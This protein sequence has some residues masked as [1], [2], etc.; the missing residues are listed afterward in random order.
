MTSM[1][2]RSGS[3]SGSKSLDH[4]PS[5]PA[6]EQ[7]KVNELRAALGP[8]TGRAE[9]YATDACLK[10][11]LRARNWNVKKSEKMLR[12]T[13]HWR[14][15]YKPEE[16]RWADVAKE[17]ETGKM[18]RA[19]FLDKQGQTLLAMHPVRQNT[20]EMD[21][22]IKHLVYCLENAIL[23][24]PIG[25]EQMIWL[26]DFRGWGIKY[27]IPIKTAREA[28]NIL[29]NHY[30]EQ[31]HVAILFSPPFVFEAFWMIVKP[32][33]DPKTFRKVKFVYS[34]NSESMKQLDG[35]L[36]KDRL[37]D[38]LDN[39]THYNHEE[40]AKLMEQDDMKSTAYWKIGE[41]QPQNGDLPD[42]GSM[43]KLEDSTEVKNQHPKPVLN[44]ETPA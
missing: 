39:P 24:L 27:T 44:G 1:L 20:S 7:V 22:Q 30:P 33:L 19:N 34:K 15:V 42:P 9:I 31:L 35:L 37:K 29:Q 13:L 4:E 16:I 26:V 36:L 40:Y 12:D 14:S 38:I 17:H 41:G 8:L 2:R 10:R 6:E 3:N 18:Y 5:S 11:Y 28:T 23:N 32:F 21:G 43:I 25:Q